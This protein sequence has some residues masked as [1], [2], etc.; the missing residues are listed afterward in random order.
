MFTPQTTFS[1]K[2]IQISEE[3]DDEIASL[4]LQAMGIS[5]DKLDKEQAEYLSSWS[6]GT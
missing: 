1:E 5:I 6:E 3:I 4:Q 2:D